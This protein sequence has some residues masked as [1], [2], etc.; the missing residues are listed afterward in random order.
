MS[1]E[2]YEVQVKEEK[3]ETILALIF[4]THLNKERLASMVIFAHEIKRCWIIN[5]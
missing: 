5:T 4:S 3:G 1:K 2:R